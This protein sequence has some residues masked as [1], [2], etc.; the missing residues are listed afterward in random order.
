MTPADYN[1]NIFAGA[2][3]DLVLNFKDSAGAAIDLTGYGT[4]IAKVFTAP[5]GTEI[6]DLSPSITDAANGEVT[7][8]VDDSSTTGLTPGQYVWDIYLVD[9]SADVVGPYLMG[10]A[11]VRTPISF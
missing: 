4:P 5:G 8:S 2:Q 9:A 1:I 11:H 7:I 10:Q 3:F 6:L